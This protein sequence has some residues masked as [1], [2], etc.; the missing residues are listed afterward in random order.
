MQ[1]DEQN[2]MCQQLWVRDPSLPRQWSQRSEAEVMALRRANLNVGK[3][4]RL[5]THSQE[6][7]PRVNNARL[8]RAFHRLSLQAAGKTNPV[9]RAH[10][11]TRRRRGSV[12]ASLTIASI[13]L[14]AGTSRAVTS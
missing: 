12:I 2:R 5:V 1:A 10:V 3:S 4:V 11:G 8:S 6:P 13:F 9:A 14:T 7:P